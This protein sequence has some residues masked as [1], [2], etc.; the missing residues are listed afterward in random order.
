MSTV[1]AAT[2]LSSGDAHLGAASLFK[3]SWSAWG[4]WSPCTTTCGSGQR[5]RVISVCLFVC[6]CWCFFVTVCYVFLNFRF[7]RLVSRCEPA[8][9]LRLALARNYKLRIAT[10]QVVQVEDIII[11]D[12]GIR[13]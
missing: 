4:S 9:E 2:C 8:L 6:V 12:C 5:L 1:S 3:P 7:L 10:C 11:L 13:A